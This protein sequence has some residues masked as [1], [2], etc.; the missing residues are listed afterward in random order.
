MLIEL[1]F[2]KARDSLEL[3]DKPLFVVRESLDEV[4]SV[5]HD[6]FIE[7][8]VAEEMLDLVEGLLRIRVLIIGEYD[9]E[10][11]ADKFLSLIKV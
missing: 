6:A 11:I 7:T 4:F 10:S 9:C 2:L 5:V 1:F 8:E 3:A